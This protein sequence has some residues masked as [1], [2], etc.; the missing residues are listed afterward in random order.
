M[1][2]S[3]KVILVTG[4]TGSFGK[5]F[6][7]IALQEHNPKAIR[8]FSRG[9]LKQQKMQEQFQKFPNNEKLRFLSVMYEIEIDYIGR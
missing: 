1:P 4:G 5:K 3:N 2:F 8:I 7:Q 6:T 9:E